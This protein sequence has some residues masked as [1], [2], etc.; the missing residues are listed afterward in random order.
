MIHDIL[1]RD[2]FEIENLAATQNRRQDLMFLS[3]CED[4]NSIGGWLFQ[5]FQKGVKC[6]RTEHVYF[7]YDIDFIFSGLRRKTHLVNQTSDII[8][9]IIAGS[10]QFMY[11]Q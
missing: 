11:I 6:R 10:I 5:G 4:K 8:D 7:V 9:R 3:S 2:S 1:I